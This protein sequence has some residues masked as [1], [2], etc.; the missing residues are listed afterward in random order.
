MLPVI[1]HARVC[2]LASLPLREAACLQT[3]CRTSGWCSPPA[4]RS[5]PHTPG[6]SR[7][8]SS[9]GPASTDST[10]PA[11]GKWT[12]TGGLW[13]GGLSSPRR[14]LPRPWTQASHTAGSR[15]T[16]LRG[17][18]GVPPS[19]QCW[20]TAGLRPESDPSDASITHPLTNHTYCLAHRAELLYRVGDP[21]GSSLT[22][23]G[24]RQALEDKR[25]PQT[26][27]IGFGGSLFEFNLHPTHPLWK[28]HG[29]VV[30]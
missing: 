27:L 15:D 25:A 10:S 9:P 30:S 24:L 3:E 23:V 26:L 13:A 5:P 1:K 4:P 18:D 12:E 2:L 14:P 19:H 16:A 7:M 29:L 22:W 17:W 20:L 11:W 8:S 28:S 6:R 21:L